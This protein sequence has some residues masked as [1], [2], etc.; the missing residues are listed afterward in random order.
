[1]H[2]FL[3]LSCSESVSHIFIYLV[4]KQIFP[5]HKYI[6][7]L[8][9]YWC[10]GFLP[11]LFFY[12]FC[13]VIRVRVH[14]ISCFG[15]KITLLVPELH[16]WKPSSISFIS[17]FH[18]F[19][20]LSLCSAPLLS[21]SLCC[22]SMSPTPLLCHQLAPLVSKRWSHCACAYFFIFIIL[23]FSNHRHVQYARSLVA[24]HRH[25]H[26]I[27][28]RHTYLFCINLWLPLEKYCCYKFF[29]NGGSGVVDLL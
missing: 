11:V 8:S 27:S 10:W 22:V 20:F 28:L 16:G 9:L 19:L 12:V 25:N 4:D 14:A 24:F 5:L 3:N 23:L 18:F 21:F 15:D 7:L 6:Y 26:P 2:W 17:D 13:I 29:Q 1:M